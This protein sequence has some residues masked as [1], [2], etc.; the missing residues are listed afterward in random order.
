MATTR[1]SRAS[2]AADQAEQQPEARSYEDQT[3][4]M[5]DMSDAQWEASDQKPEPTPELPVATGDLG[6]GRIVYFQPSLVLPDG[7]TVECPHSQWGHGKESAAAACLRKLA[8]EHG[9]KVEVLE[10]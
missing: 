5:A 10:S 2:R 6:H 9:V 3:T 7:K 1:K 8:A 4:D